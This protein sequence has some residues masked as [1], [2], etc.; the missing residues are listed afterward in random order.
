MYLWLCDIHQSWIISD[1][2]FFFFKVSHLQCYVTTNDFLIIVSYW[3]MLQ[4]LCIVTF[5]RRYLTLITYT[6]HRYQ[7]K[8]KIHDRHWLISDARKKVRGKSQI[9][10]EVD[11]HLTTKHSE[12]QSK[13]SQVTYHFHFRNKYS[14]LCSYETS[15][16]FAIV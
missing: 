8:Q 14:K 9:N 15:V 16:R 2:F 7:N 1:H 5:V 13:H 12:V 4:P 6:H 10:Y 11:E 3:Y